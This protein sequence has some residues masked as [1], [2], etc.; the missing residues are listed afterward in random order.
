MVTAHTSYF[1]D[2]VL[3]NNLSPNDDLCMEG[4]WTEWREIMRPYRNL[5]YSYDDNY[6]LESR[7]K[8]LWSYRYPGQGYHIPVEE[9]Y[10]NLRY[11]SGGLIEL[12]VLN[13]GLSPKLRI[14]PD[15]VV[16]LASADARSLEPYSL[17]EKT[18]QICTNRALEHIARK[19]NIILSYRGTIVA[20]WLSCTRAGDKKSQILREVTYHWDDDLP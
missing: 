12:G 20:R 19:I 11:S 18:L 13:P 2:R 5:V 15:E 4:V 3:R 8:P 7:L 1:S 16:Y 6:F 17:Y 9:L 10:K 14:I